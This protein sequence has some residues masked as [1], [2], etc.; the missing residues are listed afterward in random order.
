[1]EIDKAQSFIGGL[2]ALLSVILAA[3]AYGLWEFESNFEAAV[4]CLLFALW[5]KK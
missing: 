2:L 5:V 1:M 3:I 4:I